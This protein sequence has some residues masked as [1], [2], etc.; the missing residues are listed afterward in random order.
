MTIMQRQ[1][2]FSPC[3]S[4]W[5][6]TLLYLIYTHHVSWEK[7]N[8]YEKN[9]HLVLISILFDENISTSFPIPSAAGR[10]ILMPSR[11]FKSTMKLPFL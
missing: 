3:L 11:S 10:V 2:N 9:L 4:N 6:I 1:I 7:M 8:D 5:H